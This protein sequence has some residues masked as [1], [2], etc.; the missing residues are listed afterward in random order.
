MKRRPSPEIKSLM[1]RA[2]ALHQSK[3]LEEAVG[4]YV[5][6]LQLDPENAGAWHLSGVIEHQLGRHEEA[7]EKIGR[8]IHLDPIQ[9]VFFNNYGAAL[10]ALGRHIEAIGAFQRAVVLKPKY[11]DAV[12]NLGNVLEKLGH[13][14]LA[15]KSFREALALEPKHFDTLRRLGNL[16]VRLGRRREAVPYFEQAL[17]IQPRHADVLADLG[18]CWLAESRPADAVPYYLR[19]VE[20]A[21]E[22]A[23]IRFNLGNAY[24]DQDL[25]H[26]AKEQFAAACRL[27]P[28]KKGWALRSLVLCP[29]AFGSSAE[30]D[31]Y[32]T[33][34]ERGIDALLADP[35][36]LTPSEL[37][38]VGFFPPFG[39]AF[40]GR[41]NRPLKEKFAQVVR[42]II[43]PQPEAP[44]SDGR[45][46]I[47][48]V[49]T[50]GHEGLFNRCMAGIV[51]RLNPAQVEVAV[52]CPECS[53]ERIK[54]A[55]KASHVRFVTFPEKIE[56]A[57]AKIRDAR[58]DLLHYW[59]VGSDSL[60]YLLPFYRLAPVQVTSWATQVTSGVNEVDYY[61][62]SGLIEAA[63]ADEHYT[64][65]LW[66][67]QG[68]MTWQTPLPSPP[69]TRKS[70]FGLDNDRPVYLCQQTVMKF[71]PEQDLLFAAIL[72]KDP[73]G[74]LVLKE[75]RHKR[76]VEIIQERMR[77]TMPDVFDR[78]VFIPW[79][80]QEDLHRLISVADVVLDP[81]HFSAG[82]SAYDMWSLNQP[83]VT[84]PGKFNIGRYT[85]ACYKRMGFND[86]V[87]ESYQHY[88]DL[89]VRVANDASFS[90]A[91]R[92]R[93]AEQCPDMFH[94]RV[95]VTEHEALVSHLIDG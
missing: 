30:I 37:M 53:E 29:S 10:Q 46:R 8:A 35:P 11:A 87:A 93:L 27:N 47:G 79:Q 77:K 42:S 80:S 95:T 52:V 5:E 55:V 19:A 70:Y 33:E 72:R 18:N 71:H 57:V 13:S 92:R 68:L 12:S 66:R 41:T 94:D 81:V 62:S 69:A 22:R 4:L 54:L 7:M 16:Y 32:R 38:L 76:P 50:R 15:E 25:F 31:Q 60:N 6:I 64:E 58:F 91:V 89:A 44:G 2:V 86:L 75:G 26:E 39:L 45:R 84:L 36:P 83:I 9:A 1:E 14:R 73:R 23:P 59:E 48:F 65:R 90:S 88:V 78:I 40:Q 24:A 67:M 51:E 20:A 61:I 63:D 21:P 82:S 49:V 56:A 34:F 3:R 17:E 28:K 85:L 74:V 43:G